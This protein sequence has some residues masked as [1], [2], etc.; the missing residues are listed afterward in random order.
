MSSV[1]A[2]F[3][4]LGNALKK[5]L[6]TVLVVMMAALVLDVLWGVFSRRVIGHQSPWTEELA[7]YLL[8]WVSLLGA[9]AAFASGGHLGLDY[10]FGKLHAD[11]RRL[12]EIL[13]HLTVGFFAVAVMIVG[14]HMLVART[15]AAGQVSAAL[16]IPM[17]YVYLAVPISGVFLL[18][19]CAERTIETIR[20][21]PPNAAAGPR[22]DI[23]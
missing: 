15:L 4:H 14:G 1:S 5:T 22:E 21:R 23:V 2:I 16:G 8:V 20:N 17:G 7:T 6:E 18:F 3:R 11:A 12:A 19:F 10:F 9:S 13:I